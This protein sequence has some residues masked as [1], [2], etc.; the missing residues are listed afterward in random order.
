M[1]FCQPQQLS[2]LQLWCIY[3][4]WSLHYCQ[5]TANNDG[6]RTRYTLM[7]F[8]SPCFGLDSCLEYPAAIVLLWHISTCYNGDLHP[9][10]CAGLK[11]A[12]LS[13]KNICIKSCLRPIACQF[14][15]KKNNNQVLALLCPF[16]C[17]VTVTVDS[18]Q[19][20]YNKA[21]MWVQCCDRYRCG[22]LTNNDNLSCMS[23]MLAGRPI[24]N[25][26]LMKIVMPFFPTRG[27]CRKKGFCKLP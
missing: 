2:T 14:I 27:S 24:N 11:P 10:V 9:M 22:P 6:N 8:C 25:V 26:Q 23:A 7:V 5:H 4:L 12:C 16:F 19:R 21:C 15:R 13:R 18:A 17:G 1:I 20:K 3:K